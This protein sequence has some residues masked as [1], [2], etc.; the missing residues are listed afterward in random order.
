MATNDSVRLTRH[1]VDE[2]STLD[3]KVGHTVTSVSC[4]GGVE[5]NQSVRWMVESAPVQNGAG[6]VGVSET[7][8][9]DV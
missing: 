5:Y 2:E 1:A 7:R 4:G 6:Q 9:V 8:R 3:V